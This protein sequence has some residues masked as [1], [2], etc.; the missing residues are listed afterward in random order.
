[1][2]QLTIYF[3]EQ[4]DEVPPNEGGEDEMVSVRDSS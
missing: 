4:P 1:M 3:R 2:M